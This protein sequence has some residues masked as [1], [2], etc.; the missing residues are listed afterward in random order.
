MAQVFGRETLSQ[1]IMVM[2]LQVEEKDKD[3]ARQTLP[4]RLSPLRGGGWT[5]YLFLYS[6][7]CQRLVLSLLF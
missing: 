7:P 6:A 2:G 3:V 1:N 4:F 5:P